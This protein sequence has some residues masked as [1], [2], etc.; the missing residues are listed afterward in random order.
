LFCARYQVPLDYDDPGGVQ[1]SIALVK[2]PASDPAHRVGSLFVNPG[3]PGGSG[4]DFVVDEGSSLFTRQV[5]ARFD[6]IGFD[7]RGIYRSDQLRCFGTENAAYAT[8]HRSAYP[9]SAARRAKWF[10]RDRALDSACGSHGSAILDHMSTANVA[11]DLD[12]LRQAVGDRRL[13]YY[14]ASYGSFLGDTYAN[15]FPGRVRSVVIDGVP[16]PVAWTTGRGGGVTLPFSTRV[17]SATGSM[18]TLHEFFRL[19]DAGGA[20]CPF[21]PHAATKYWK[22]YRR[23]RA[24]PLHI[25]G[26]SMPYDETSL[27]GD[28]LDALYSSADWLNFAR[29]L[30]RLEHRA[31]LSTLAAVRPAVRGYYLNDVEGFPGVA[32]SDSIN[33]STSAAWTRAAATAR[34]KDGLFG[35]IWTWATS[36]CAHWPGH[37]ADRYLGPFTHY[38]THPVLVVGN[39]FDPATPYAGAVTAARLL[40]NSR[41]LT[42][43][44]WGHTSLFMSTC[45]DK[46]IGNYL[47]TSR[48]PARGTV[49]QSD[50]VPFRSTRTRPF[51]AEG[52]AAPSRFPMWHL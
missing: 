52:S 48:P 41:L 2:R 26:M 22:L 25:R 34:R 33:P 9:N 5:R 40:P 8:A 20:N 18:K 12:R 7:P 27:V 44:G 43:H 51:T 3:G 49:C 35:P 50:D 1:I 23:L 17:N 4:V 13:N 29:T 21:G 32:C 15:L 42:V 39:R 19:C 31:K 37:D 45:A 38:T 11:R 16:D 36:V 47:L 46:A 10:A 14:G 24:H 6:I 28:S 30:V